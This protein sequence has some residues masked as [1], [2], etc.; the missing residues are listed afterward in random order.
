MRKLSITALLIIVAV[1]FIHSQQEKKQPNVIIVFIDDMGYGDLGTYGATGYET[2]NVDKM[3]AE[4]MKFTNFYVAQPVCS[5]SRAGIL[6]GCYPNRISVPGVIA[7]GRGIGLNSDEYTIAE[8]FK[9]QG[10][11]TAAYGKWHV[12]SEKEFLP[13]QHGFDEFLGLPYSN[14]FWPRS[15]ITG[16]KLQEGN[17]KRWKMQELP[18]I[19]GN[20]KVGEIKSMEDQDNLTTLY[21][22]KA[23]SFINKNS[24]KPF[25]V[26]LAHSMGHIPLGVSK[27]FRGKSE[28]GLY[29]D[30]VMELDWSLGQINKALKENNIEEN[31]IVIFTS[32]NGPWLSFGNHA[33]SA[34]GLREGKMTNWEGGQRVPFIIKWPDATPKG[35]V[36][37]NLGCTI[38]LLPT[39]AAITDGKLSHNKIDG[40]NITS[41]F[42][43]DFSTSPRESILYYFGNNNL[44]AVRKGNW[45]LVFPHTWKS[46]ETKSGNDGRNGA[47]INK[48]IKAAQLFDMSRD[49][50][51]RYNVIEEHPEIVKDI[52]IIAEQARKELGD[53]NVGIQKGTEVRP[54]G[55]IR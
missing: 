16:K 12:G 2:P 33:G 1:N 48:S 44:N 27:K 31:T 25:F 19:E 35:T 14:D 47:K 13:L 40:I 30:V 41:L 4:G 34:G 37:D 53:S 38:D 20:D 7:P 52:I 23:V 36:C 43:G 21:T 9:D 54:V 8:M 10:Y 42:K 32:D 24:K 6:T 49:P 55:I 39:F 18:L 29:G 28:Q 3:A 26:Y 15:S 50:G 51:E 46:Y 11:R 5:A 17:G 22:E 45:K